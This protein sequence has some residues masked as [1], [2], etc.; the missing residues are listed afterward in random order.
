MSEILKEFNI[1]V[2]ITGK[3]Y[4]KETLVS[5]EGINNMV[6]WNLPNSN[7]YKDLYVKV[8]S[9]AG[10]AILNISKTN[11]MTLIYLGN[12]SAGTLLQIDTPPWGYLVQSTLLANSEICYLYPL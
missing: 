4:L 9:G 11:T 6:Y 5:N 3:Y 12:Q 7:S 8:Y 2:C 1:L 10:L